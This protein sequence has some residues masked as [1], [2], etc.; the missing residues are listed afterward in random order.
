MPEFT[1]VHH[2][3]LSVRDLDRSSGWYCDTLGLTVAREVHGEGFRRSILHFPGELP[4]LG[5][6]EHQ[7]NTGDAFSEARAGLD[8]VAF[9]VRSPAE[10]EA[11]QRRFGTKGIVHSRPRQ[12]LLV[13]VIRTTSSWRCAPGDPKGR[14][15]A[16][17]C[18]RWR[19]KGAKRV[20]G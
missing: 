9:T 15:E 7:A 13:S 8:H 17:V 5:L 6:T 11:W 4:V 12:G 16:V 1:E 20:R 10:L 3:S 18:A 14:P 19:R 2:I